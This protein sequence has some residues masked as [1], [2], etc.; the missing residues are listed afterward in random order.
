M[1]QHSNSQIKINPYITFHTVIFNINSSPIALKTLLIFKWFSS[2]WKP[3]LHLRTVIYE[4]HIFLFKICG[5]WGISIWTYFFNKRNQSY[6]SGYT[7]GDFLLWS[8]GLYTW[9][10]ETNILFCVKHFQH[11]NIWICSHNLLEIDLLFL[12]SRFEVSLCPWSTWVREET[13]Q[14]WKTA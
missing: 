5:C 3:T 9:S 8:Y 12:W 10:Y 2:T 13:F 14:K 4:N 6:S 1:Y 7:S 11:F